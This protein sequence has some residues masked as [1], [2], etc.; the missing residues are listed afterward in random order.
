MTN[1]SVYGKAI[2]TLRNRVD[3]R[4]LADSKGYKDLVSKP[5][6]VFQKI[7]NKNLIDVPKFKEMPSLDKLAYAGIC[8]FNLKFDAWISLQMCERKI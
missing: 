8:I 4:L 7:L 1:N 5:S 2:G 3:V 6:F